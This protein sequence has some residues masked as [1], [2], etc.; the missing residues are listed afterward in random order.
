MATKTVKRKNFETRVKDLTKSFEKFNKDSVELSYEV[1]EESLA[2][3][4]Q[5]QDLIAKSLKKSTRLFAKQQDIML[6]ALE[7]VKSQWIDNNEKTMKLLE[8]EGVTKKWRKRVDSVVS[9]A[10]DIVE[11]VIDEGKD[12]V[13]KAKK[14]V[15]KVRP[16][17]VIDDLTAINGIGPKTNEVLQEAGVKNFKDLARISFK[18]LE[19]I[20]EEGGLNSLTANAK[21]WIK[22][23]KTK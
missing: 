4:K 19:K 18:R 8:L 21:E 13:E 12:L 23:A 16:K 9:P 22:E 15:E 7:E 17:E 1:V 11:D 14:E 6:T 20:L 10:R 3:G 2:L 5:W